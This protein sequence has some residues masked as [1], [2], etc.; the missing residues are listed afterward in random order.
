MLLR[1]VLLPYKRGLLLT[2]L[3][4]EYRGMTGTNIS[5]RMLGYPSLLSL[6]Q[7]MQD[8][9]TLQVLDS[10]H[11]IVFATPDKSTQHIASMVSCQKDNL[12]G[13]NRYTGRVLA[14]KS[15]FA[16]NFSKAVTE[17]P[18][19]QVVRTDGT[20]SALVKEKL[21]TLL[22]KFPTGLLCSQLR[23]QYRQLHGEDLDPLCCGQPSVLE[24][25][26][27]V[28][29]IL[30][31]ERVDHG[32]DWL[33][34]PVKQ[35]L[36]GDIIDRASNV[37]Y[38]AS[39][40]ITEMSSFSAHSDILEIQ[41]LPETVAVG[42]CVRVVVT[43]VQS[44]S[45]LFIQLADMQEELLSLMEKVSKE[46]EEAEE[47][48]VRRMELKEG[49]VVACMID[50]IWYRVMVVKVK[51]MTR[52][53]V[54]L[55]DYGIIQ[56]VLISGLR[57]LSKHV[58]LY[59]AQAVPVSLALPSCR[60]SWPEGTGT[61]FKQM[62]IANQEQGG[63]VLAKVE[64]LR[65]H[66]SKMVVWLTDHKNVVINDILASG[67]AEGESGD[68]HLRILRQLANCEQLAA[69]LLEKNLSDEILEKL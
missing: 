30:H 47:R 18:H 67:G 69:R 63:S 8:V 56:T 19:S 38:K 22:S 5:Y 52:V 68:R 2:E 33:L 35:V 15:S 42:D 4:R 36:C 29:D 54:F 34:V 57:Y 58:A 50:N 48:E 65:D 53:K 25:C 60:E 61:R 24:L 64:K 3:E 39:A 41:K 7:D 20:V 13:Y 62:M 44:P 26:C 28:P 66:R 31:L 55:I 43:G 27:Q 11:Q 45:K 17:Y 9:A 6:I 23:E 32:R 14:G 49:M 59:P 1:S 37:K 12:E 40:D 10:G 16:N 51:D 46:M 21:G